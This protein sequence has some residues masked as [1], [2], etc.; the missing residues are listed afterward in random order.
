MGSTLLIS[1]VLI[2][3]TF[4]SS[5][6]CSVRGLYLYGYR[7]K[8]GITEP[9]YH[10]IAILSEEIAWKFSKT[11]IQS[12]IVFVGAYLLFSGGEDPIHW[13]GLLL[14]IVYIGWT[15]YDFISSV[16]KLKAI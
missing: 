4:V 2:C 13:I 11:S 15:I 12:F 16:Q 1:Q 10:K 8:R 5:V 6:V 9:L 14:V 7:K 3:L